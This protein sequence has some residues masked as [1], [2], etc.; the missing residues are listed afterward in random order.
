MITFH[1]GSRHPLRR[2]PSDVI[3]KCKE[4]GIN[5]DDIKNLQGYIN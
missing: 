2:N 3:N 4:Y 5:L 1:D